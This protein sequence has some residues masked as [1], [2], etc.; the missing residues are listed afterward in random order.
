MD[1][2]GL[3]L[4]MSDG[5]DGQVETASLWG[6]P[7]PHPEKGGVHWEQLERLISDWFPFLIPTNTAG[8]L[9]VEMVATATVGHVLLACVGALRVDACLP[10]GARGTDT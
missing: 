5:M 7:S 6:T 9:L 3:C 4:E 2:K 8:S 1:D 10:N